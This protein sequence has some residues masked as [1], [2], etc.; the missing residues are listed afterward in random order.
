MNSYEVDPHEWE[1]SADVFPLQVN[2]ILWKVDKEHRRNSQALTSTALKAQNDIVQMMGSEE[3]VL[4]VVEE[5]VRK[6]SEETV[7][8]NNVLLVQKVQMDEELHA[9]ARYSGNHL[10]SA[11]VHSMLKYKINISV[12]F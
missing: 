8:K 6:D 7:P 3:T 10:H 5:L 9:E 4:R 1:H 12:L 2:H 11:G